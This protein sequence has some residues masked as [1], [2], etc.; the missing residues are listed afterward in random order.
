VGQKWAKKMR[1]D[2][3]YNRFTSGFDF[4]ETSSRE[5]HLWF[6]LTKSCK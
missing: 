2:E 3:L 6:E 4:K 1:T 5:K